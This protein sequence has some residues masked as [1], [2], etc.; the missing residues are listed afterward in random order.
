MKQPTAFV[1]SEAYHVVISTNF[2][3]KRMASGQVEVNVWKYTE[4]G[5]ITV[6]AMCGAS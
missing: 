1:S 2:H 5:G 3:V 6:T 4:E